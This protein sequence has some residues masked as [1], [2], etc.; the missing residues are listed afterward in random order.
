MIKKQ[1]TSDHLINWWLEKYHHT[2]MDKVVAEN[3]WIIDKDW[4]SRVF[5]DRYPVTQQQCDEWERWAI[6][7]VAKFNRL[8]VKYVKRMF[9]PIYLN[10][11]PKVIRDN[12]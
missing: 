12:P 11:S 10:C 9:W 8:G 6:L 7:E 3:N 4:D 5:Y 1:L 2:N